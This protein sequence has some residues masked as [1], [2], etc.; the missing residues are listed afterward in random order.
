MSTSYTYFQRIYQ[1]KIQ[2]NLDTI[3]SIVISKKYQDT[4][5]LQNNNLD[6]NEIKHNNKKTVRK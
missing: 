5:K 3:K 1:Y 6:C 4:V 2:A